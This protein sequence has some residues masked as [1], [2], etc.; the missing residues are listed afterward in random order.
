MSHRRS[1]ITGDRTPTDY[2]IAYPDGDTE[3]SA[4]VVFTL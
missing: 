3:M 4:D 1:I 2:R